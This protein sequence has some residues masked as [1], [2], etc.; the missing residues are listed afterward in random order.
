MCKA[1]YFPNPPLSS[2]V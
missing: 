1:T 2:F